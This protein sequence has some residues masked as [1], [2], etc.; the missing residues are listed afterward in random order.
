M[1]T[2]PSDITTGKK[3]K[4]PKLEYVVLCTKA[5]VDDGG[6]LSMIQ[7]FDA[8][9]APGFPARHPEMNIVIKWKGM[10]NDTQTF[11]QQVKIVNEKTGEIIAK[12]EKY[13]FNFSNDKYFFTKSNIVDLEFKEKGRY[14]IQIY[15]NGKRE[16]IEKEEVFEVKKK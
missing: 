2:N 6:R 9:V 3:K 12:S 4:Y 15:L 11:Y 5:F 1:K 7:C 14:R 8:V 16:N 10:E 13:K